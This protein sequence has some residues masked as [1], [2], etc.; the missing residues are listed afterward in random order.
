MTMTSTSRISTVD[1]KYIS[2]STHLPTTLLQKLVC[3]AR[4]QHYL[5]TFLYDFFITKYCGG[6]GLGGGGYELPRTTRKLLLSGVIDECRDGG[7]P[8]DEMREYVGES[9]EDVEYRLRR[10]PLC[11][12]VAEQISSYKVMSYERTLRTI[13][14]IL[15]I[16]IDVLYRQCHLFLCT[17]E[18][19]KQLY[20][21]PCTSLR[22]S[23]RD[24]GRIFVDAWRD[25]TLQ[26]YY[27]RTYPTQLRVFLNSELLSHECNVVE[28]YRQYLNIDSI[29]SDDMIFDFYAFESED[30]KKG[31][32]VSRLI[33]TLRQL[34][35]GDHVYPGYV[36]LFKVMYT[37]YIE[38]PLKFL[39]L[40][41]EYNTV[42]TASSSVMVKVDDTIDNGVSKPRRG[43]KR[44]NP[45]KII[46]D[47]G[48]EQTRRQMWYD[49][50]RQHHILQNDDDEDV[51]T[52]LDS[53][54]QS[55][56]ECPP[57]QQQ[58][59]YGKYVKDISSCV[60]PSP[61]PVTADDDSAAE[62]AS[63]QQQKRSHTCRR[64]RKSRSYYKKLNDY[65]HALMM[66]NVIL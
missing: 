63:Q 22:V 21:S 32:N 34:E 16:N 1:S 48:Q 45:T 27:G 33:N 31:T 41:N 50:H 43:R 35:I 24:I 51:D 42:V 7:I 19:T 26:C 25:Y 44:K 46:D 5:F 62:I 6:D 65:R 55:L 8:I 28:Y 61:P 3:P 14:V 18:S 37:S 4:Y 47:Y 38:E 30:V 60:V 12:Y 29:V 15:E 58:Q 56:T 39:K 64:R 2:K 10:F 13:T 52:M 11:R 66:T 53:I 36:S 54:L 20:T 17:D 49:R 59:H 40:Q 23:N 57:P 9:D